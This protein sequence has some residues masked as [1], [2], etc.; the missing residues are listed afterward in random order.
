MSTMPT[1]AVNT[2]TTLYEFIA[3]K[4]QVFSEAV[5]GIASACAKAAIRAR[6]LGS[7]SFQKAERKKTAALEST[8]TKTFA[9]YW[10]AEKSKTTLH[11]KTSSNPVV[12]EAIADHDGVLV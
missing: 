3:L 6:A 11:A 12:A 9:S 5:A 2:P 4:S 10:R 1:P 7:R 8:P